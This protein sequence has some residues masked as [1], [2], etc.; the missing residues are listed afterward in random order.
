MDQTGPMWEKLNQIHIQKALHFQQFFAQKSF[1]DRK[2][3][4]LDKTKKGELSVI[5]AQN[6]VGQPI[7]YCISSVVGPTGEIESIFVDPDFRADGLGRQ[8]A[9]RSLEWLDARHPARTILTVACGNEEV[10]PFY[11]KLG[12][13]PRIVEL[14]RMEN[15][16]QQTKED[17]P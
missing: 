11:E 2:K 7:G 4:L 13:Y 8:L 12:F 3:E 17:T 15:S 1:E 14:Q 16:A 10:F 9:E 6:Q 5:L